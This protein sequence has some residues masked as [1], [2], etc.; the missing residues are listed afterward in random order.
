MDS[1]LYF[2]SMYGFLVCFLFLIS[3]LCCF[4]PKNTFQ[5][6]QVVRRNLNLFRT[7]MMDLELA[8]LRQQTTVYQHMTEE[9]R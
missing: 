3:F 5:E 8:M 6:L 4:F 2:F 1:I 7:Q 9:E